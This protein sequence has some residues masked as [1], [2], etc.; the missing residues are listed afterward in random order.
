MA[1]AR[2]ARTTEA[3][4]VVNKIEALLA[5]LPAAPGGLD[6]SGDVTASQ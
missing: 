2:P 6:H 1:L 3:D 5:E 4:G